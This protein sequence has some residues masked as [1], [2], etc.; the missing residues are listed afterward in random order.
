MDGQ[1]LKKNIWKIQ[2]I[3]HSVCWIDPTHGGKAR[4]ARSKA[5]KGSEHVLLAE[6]L[7]YRV[8]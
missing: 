1:D 6:G 5:F 3:H 4:V 8:S 2:R 7:L